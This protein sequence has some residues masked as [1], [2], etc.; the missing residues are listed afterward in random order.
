MILLVSSFI[1]DCDLALCS[2]VFGMYLKKLCFWEV[3]WYSNSLFASTTLFFGFFWFSVPYS[4]RS[5]HSQ[6]SRQ[7]FV[8]IDC[9]VHRE[10]AAYILFLQDDHGSL[11]LYLS[12]SYILFHNFVI[13]DYLT[14]F[15]KERT[16]WMSSKCFFFFIATILRDIFICLHVPVDNF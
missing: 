7:S 16:L 13:Q 8:T 12:T 11:V 4:L 6:S 9:A 1:N 15:K 10:S 5:P 14:E 3:V 2:K